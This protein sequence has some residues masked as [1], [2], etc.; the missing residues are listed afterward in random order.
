MTEPA[1]TMAVEDVLT[2]IRRLLAQDIPTGSGA[3]VA[4]GQ[5]SLQH[6]LAA[7]EAAMVSRLSPP[8]GEPWTA[9]TAEAD[10][11]SS[12]ERAFLPEAAGP[13]LTPGIPA[14]EDGPVDD[15]P[16]NAPRAEADPFTETTPEAEQI[17]EIE[18]AQEI[19][20]APFIAVDMA[21]APLATSFSFRHTAEI[22]RLQLVTPAPEEQSVAA[23]EDLS[24]PTPAHAPAALVP[25]IEEVPARADPAPPVP[26]A[27]PERVATVEEAAPKLPPVPARIDEPRSLFDEP[28]ELPIDLQVLRRLI[29]EVLREELQGPLGERMTRNVRKLVRAEIR[30][31]LAEDTP[32]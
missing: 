1:K 27:E 4:E 10:R 9:D 12:A 15:L 11:E 25:V 29:G 23:D 3:A 16:A 32:G 28:E 8:V 13:G 26:D 20:E 18:E 2:S 22:R 30:R 7:L 17:R 5:M 6:T 14:A 19:E 31:A 21:D 24:P